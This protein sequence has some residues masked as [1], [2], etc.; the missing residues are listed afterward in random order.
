MKKW[1]MHVDM[2][3]FYASIE[4][5]DHEEYQGKPV[6]VGGLSSRGVVATAS[7]EARKFG[8]HSAMSM[9]EAKKRC[10]Q[11]IFVWGDHKL[12]HA[13]SQQIFSIFMEFSPAIEPL[14]LDEAFM[15]VSGMEMLVSDWESYAHKLKNRIKNEVGLVASVGIA[16]N[17]FLAK[18]ASD[19]KK[20]D[21]LV[22]VRQEDAKSLLQ[23]LPLRALW[24]VGKK[25]AQQLEA[26]GFYTVGQ[27]AAAD[28]GFLFKHFGTIAHRLVDLAN[29]CDERVIE[30]DRLAQSIGNEITFDHDLLTRGQVEKNLLALAEKVGWRLRLSACAARTITLKIRSASFK[31]ITRSRTLPLSTNFDEDIYKA[32]V[33]LYQSAAI[34]EKIRLLGITGNQLV[35]NEQVNLFDDNVKKKSLYR[36]MDDLKERFGEKIITKANLI[37]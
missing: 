5:R 10:P 34:T 25:T 8:V 12:Y 3:A 6:I 7:Y 24:G 33:E 14:S 18:L 9:A 36:T 16:P 17:K 1:I 32:A 26:L 20:P 27:I 31:T 35:T 22:I 11:G 4:Q 19:L 13:V 21:G 23:D 30:P 2:D 15:D 37:E 28:A 29:G